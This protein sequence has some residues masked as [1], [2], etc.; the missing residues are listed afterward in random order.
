MNNDQKNNLPLLDLC[1]QFTKGS[2]RLNEMVLH[3]V[4]S[5]PSPTQ[6]QNA[7]FPYN[8]DK[9]ICLYHNSH[10]I[11]TQAACFLDRNFEYIEGSYSNHIFFNRI[12][13]D[14]RIVKYKEKFLASASVY[15]EGQPRTVLTELQVSGGVITSV[16]QTRHEFTN[17]MDWPEY[18]FKIEKNWLPWVHEGK[19]FYTYSL[20]P[21]VI[22]EV[23]IEGDFSIKKIASTK[24]TTDSW[25]A[26]QSWDDP[27]YRLNT[28]PVRIEDGT[29][30]GTFHTLSYVTCAPTTTEAEQ[31]GPWPTPWH[32]VIIPNNR[33][34]AYWT[35]FYLF[36]GN[37]PYKVLK[38]SKE[39]FVSPSYIFPTDWPFQAPRFGGNPFWPASMMIQKDTI[40]LCG[41]SMDACCAFCCFSLKE[42]LQSLIPVAT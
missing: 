11:H 8:D 5:L 37:Y 38:I 36:E 10:Q 2:V 32:K 14:P 21:H 3:R 1:S 33:V 16:P 22:L 9:F 29:Y 6:Y 15:D 24:W 42:V 28:P 19:F 26:N 39:P 27:I 41:G 35:G 13:G 4:K 23:D 7:I 30:L 20:N 31:F 12:N 34:R 17:I 25:W 40:L 18:I